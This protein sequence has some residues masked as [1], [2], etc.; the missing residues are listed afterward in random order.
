MNKPCQAETFPYSKK[1]PVEW[2]RFASLQQIATIPAE[3]GGKQEATRDDG[4]PV[5]S[6]GANGFI[7]ALRTQDQRARTDHG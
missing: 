6:A 3:G 1:T 2:I 4:D 7:C 5:K